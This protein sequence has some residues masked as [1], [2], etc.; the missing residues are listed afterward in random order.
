[1]SDVEVSIDFAP[2]KL[3]AFS[4]NEMQMNIILKNSGANIYWSEC[5]V[6]VSSPLSLAHDTELNTGRTRMG[7]LK[8]LSSIS[9]P[10]RIYTRPNNYPDNYKFSIV[11]YI[12]DGDG[13]ISERLE[14]KMEIACVSEESTKAV[15][16]K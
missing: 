16:D 14:K 2:S 8:P 9:R 7:L 12:Y 1:M 4:R 3:K 13:A 10:I 5:E 6:V 15:Q 11:A